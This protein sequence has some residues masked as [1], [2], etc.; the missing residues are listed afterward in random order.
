VAALNDIPGFQCRPAEG[1]F[2]AFPRITGALDALGF[3]SD[4]EMTEFLLN[5]ADVALVPGIAFGAP[6]YLRFSFACSLE[7]LQEAVAR[8]G[9]AIAAKA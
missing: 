1:T 4:A 8:I 2:Y 9:R 6:G 7:S 5:E 3:S